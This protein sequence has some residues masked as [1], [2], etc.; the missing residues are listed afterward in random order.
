MDLDLGELHQIFAE[1]AA[2]HLEAI[3]TTLMALESGE[4][5]DRPLDKLLRRTHTLKGAAATVGLTLIG[6]GAH[7]LEECLAALRGQAVSAEQVDRLLSATDL[8]RAMVEQREA[9]EEQVELAR[10]LAA[11]L[12]TVCPC[13]PGEAM[14]ERRKG[15]RRRGER[16]QE[17]RREEEPRRVWVD[18]SRLDLLMDQAAELLID[19]TR[20][21]RRLEDLH[22]LSAG[23]GQ[24]VEGVERMREG[25][26]DPRLL[27][28]LH[29]LAA[30]LGGSGAA[31]G[32]AVSQLDRDLAALRHTSRT[33]QDQLVRVRMMPLGWLHLRFRRILR[34]I[35]REL[36]RRVRLE[37]EDEAAELD[38]SVVELITDPLIQLLRNAVVHGIEPP[39]ERTRAGKPECG[40]VT[41]RAR[42][43]GDA[44]VLE[45]SDDGRGIEPE[46][47]RGALAHQRALRGVDLARLDDQELLDTIFISGV[48]TR[49]EVDRLAGRGVGLDVVRQNVSRL[50][51]E[52]Q[53]RSRPGQGTV[54][55]LRIPFTTAIAEA[56][57]FKE[58]DHVYGL[59]AAHVERTLTARAEDLRPAGDGYQVRTDGG[60]IPLL[61]LNFLLG[62]PPPLA[63]RRDHRPLGAQPPLSVIVVKLSALR[64]GITCSRVVGPREIV[65]KGLG[66]LLAPHPLLAAATVSGS[67]KVQ[68]VLDVAFLARV[69]TFGQRG[70]APAGGGADQG[71]DPVEARV[72][73]PAGPRVLLVDD[74]SAVR[75]R[76]ARVLRD[77]G[78]QVEQASD[79]EDAWDKLQRSSYALLLTDL[80]MPR[81]H[82]L[83]LISRCRAASPL[84]ALPI[85][86][87]SSRA[88]PGGKE[89]A[90]RRGAS[91]FVAKPVDPPELLA[92]LAEVAPI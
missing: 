89:Q 33:I 14:P 43:Q 82:G 30:E 46:T 62:T 68:F 29:D 7:G 55:T 50:G 9:P 51:G 78:Y 15:E 4:T 44:I 25:V 39:E 10:R 19:R 84:A 58:G 79:G 18:L 2:E 71:G 45:V 65:L 6:D 48:T 91:H 11:L 64:F 85:V 60:W 87:I 92:L 83:E 27:G 5:I 23:L 24:L 61:P 52:I 53:V 59:A 38:R 16:R 47:L 76:V 74:S 69:V 49:R 17:A 36:G 42:H 72:A 77:G 73:E 1:E 63:L 57:L 28:E 8:L 37:I 31:L 86:V 88:S 32:R 66:S 54:F 3:S 75:E 80:E 12:T 56:L 20:V 13:D 70:A 41:L 22:G 67:N 34:Q 40:L 90:L 21:E 35:G 26:S 81:L